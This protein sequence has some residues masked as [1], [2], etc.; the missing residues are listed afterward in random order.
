MFRFW[1]TYSIVKKHPEGF[2]FSGTAEMENGT[3]EEEEVELVKF[4]LHKCDRFVNI[5]ANVGYYLCMASKIGTPSVAFEPLSSNL[6]ILYRNLILNNWSSNIEIFPLALGSKTQLSK[7]YGQGT[8]A[9]LIKSWANSD[10]RHFKIVPTTTIDNFL[11]QKKAGEKLL[12]LADI[13][14]FELEMLRGAK[15][16][17]KLD[18]KPTWIIEVS[19]NEH[20]PSQFDYSKASK[21]FRLMW[22]NGYKTYFADL[23]LIEFTPQA[24]TK[25]KKSKN[26]ETRSINILFLDKKIRSLTKK[27]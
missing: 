4:L 24:F 8:G 3:F 27:S 19:F 10:P 18:P 25:I 5:G 23:N 26:K 21:V 9:S 6:T 13:E 11:L 15:K 7:I 22:A 16:T 2:Y 1:L 12:I 20:L 14:G 17:L